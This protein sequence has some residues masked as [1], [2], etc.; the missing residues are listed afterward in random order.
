MIAERAAAFTL[1]EALGER[2]VDVGALVAALAAEGVDLA[3][4]AR[5]DARDLLERLELSALGRRRPVTLHALALTF[6]RLARRLEERTQDPAL[7]MATSLRRRALEA[8][9]L[10]AREQTYLTT[11]LGRISRAEERETVK[12]TVRTRAE[13]VL[14]EWLAEASE[15]WAQRSPRAYVLLSLLR[16]LE[17]HSAPLATRAREARERAIEAMLAPI[18]GHLEALQTRSA[19]IGERLPAIFILEEAWRASGLDGLLALR[20]MERVLALG[21]ELRSTGK[22]EELGVL[23]TRFAP[24][25]EQLA[26]D[27]AARGETASYAAAVADAFVQRSSAP[28]EVQVHVAMCE[29]ALQ[30]CPRHRLAES[31][32]AFFLAQR[33]W[34]LLEGTVGPVSPTDKHAIE[35]L[36]HRARTLDPNDAKLAT[37]IERYQKRTGIKV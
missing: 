15:E 14:A 7:V 3:P 23:H 36:I 6:E 10:L 26:R 29:R 33:A 8:W 18:A 13:A 20:A 9:L 35:A 4:A 31:M 17:A 25:F 34:S 12:E 21:W 37:V 11:L 30:I 22:Y 19:P 28:G 5:G 1:A 24:M 16:L 2:S 32:L 27:V